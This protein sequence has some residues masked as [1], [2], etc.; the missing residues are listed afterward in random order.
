[1]ILNTIAWLVLTKQTKTFEKQ[2]ESCQASSPKVKDYNLPPSPATS[3][4]GRLLEEIEDFAWNRMKCCIAIALIHLLHRQILQ[5]LH[6][7]DLSQ[8]MKY[9]KRSKYY[10]VWGL[11]I[12]VYSQ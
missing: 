7:S 2:D 12:I 8:L 4:G 9:I 11:C 10:E 6:L 3:P 5:F 1:M